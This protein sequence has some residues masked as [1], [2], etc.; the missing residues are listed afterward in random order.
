M[1]DFSSAWA[2]ELFA[3][4]VFI[5]L[6]K[7]NHLWEGLLEDLDL[8]AFCCHLVCDVGEGHEEHESHGDRI[9]S[10]F[11]PKLHLS[12]S[13]LSVSPPS[14]SETHTH[15]QSLSLSPLSVTAQGFMLSPLCTTPTSTLPRQGKGLCSLSV[16]HMWMFGFPKTWCTQIRCPALEWEEAKEF[17]VAYRGSTLDLN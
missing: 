13:S 6:K 5:K 3:C 1:W 9:Q 4:Q 16:S 2:R 14:L 11:A 10:N 8:M 7:Q 15:K 12:L 17:P